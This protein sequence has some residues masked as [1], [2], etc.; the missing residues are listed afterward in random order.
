LAGGVPGLGLVVEE[1]KGV[2]KAPQASWNVQKQCQDGR[3]LALIDLKLA[4]NAVIYLKVL[5]KIYSR[6]VF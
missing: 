1:V 2:K 5:N 4:E 3:F 6:D